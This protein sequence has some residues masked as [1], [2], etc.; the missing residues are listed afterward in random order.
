MN[1]PSRAL[2]AIYLFLALIALSGCASTHNLKTDGMNPLGGGFVE[3][4]VRP[5]FYRLTATAN[6]APWPSFEA[7]RQTWRG[8]ADQLCGE[9]AYQEIGESQDAGYRGSTSAYVHPGLMV[10]APSFNT[11][12]SGYV[13]CN[14]SGMTREMAI[15]Y[16]DDQAV[17]QAAQA[18]ARANQLMSDRRKEIEALGGS[19]CGNGDA[20]AS[21]ESFFRRGKILLALYEYKAAMTCFMQAQDRG[22]G[23]TV[24]RDSCS[25]IGTMYEL[26][27][28]VEKDMTQA[29]SWFRKAGY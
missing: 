1:Q 3:D 23:T 21:A 10:N 7:A 19:N 26:G 28:G 29:M 16:L 24:Y 9:N 6:L 8:R 4:E 14:A 12:L 20:N 25:S 5:G 2:W 27:W 11:S 13:L 22:Q 17:A 18:A 15:K